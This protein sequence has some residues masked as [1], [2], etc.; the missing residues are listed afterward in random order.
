MVDHA[1]CNSC[2]GSTPTGGTTVVLARRIVI[3]T[4]ENADEVL[5][6]DAVCQLCP[7]CQIVGTTRRLELSSSMPPILDA[8]SAA[9][10]KYVKETVG[11]GESSELITLPLTCANCKGLIHLGAKFIYVEISQDTEVRGVVNPKNKVAVAN[12]CGD[13]ADKTWGV[14]VERGLLSP[15]PCSTPDCPACA[16]LKIE[17][18]L[19]WGTSSNNSAARI[20]SPRVYNEIR[21]RNSAFDW[22]W[23]SRKFGCD[24]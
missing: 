9:L 11:R 16:P 2:N 13:C 14:Q 8:E 23:R 17:A 10:L 1:H 6:G 24:P 12:V 5:V 4:H 18:S 21:K 20:A 19:V 15:N 22:N 3:R 7:R